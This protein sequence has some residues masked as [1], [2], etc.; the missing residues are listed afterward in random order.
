V[1]PPWKLARACL[2]PCERGREIGIGGGFSPPWALLKRGFDEY[3]G[4]S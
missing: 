4:N 2:F 1:G 3:N